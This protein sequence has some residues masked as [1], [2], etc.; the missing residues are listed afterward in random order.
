MSEPGEQIPILHPALQ[1]YPS[2][3]TALVRV[4]GVLYQVPMQ[5][6][7]DEAVPVPVN[8]LMQARTAVHQ[9]LLTLRSG[10]CDD[11]RIESAGRALVAGMDEPPPTTREE[12][13]RYL[14]Q[15][16]KRLNSWLPMW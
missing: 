1:K 16:R 10:G 6:D 7:L 3:P 13:D 4:D 5:R 14:E 2:S 15:L 11:Y 8:D 12:L 9:L